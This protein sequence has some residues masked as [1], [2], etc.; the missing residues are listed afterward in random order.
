MAMSTRT[1]PGPSAN[2]ISKGGLERRYAVRLLG[3]S[4][5]CGL[6]KK[7]WLRSNVVLAG[8]SRFVLVGNEWKKKGKKCNLHSVVYDNKKAIR[9]Q[10]GINKPRDSQKK[11]KSRS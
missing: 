6:D 9:D 8:V 1:I 11:S 3:G 4:M 10:A 5:E 2:P 7:G